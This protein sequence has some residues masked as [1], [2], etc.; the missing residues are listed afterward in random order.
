MT[1]PNILAFETYDQW[2]AEP[3]AQLFSVHQFP[4]NGDLS[5]ITVDTRELI[6]AFAFK[7]HSTLG[8]EIMDAFPNLGLI[9]NYGVGY[10]TIDVD[11]ASKRGIKVT[12]TPDV[13]TDDVA[14][15]GVGM[16]LALN[17]GMV[18]ADAWVRSVNWAA[19]GA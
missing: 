7:G 15:L 13:L 12:N 4:S 9:A 5:A 17:R 3:M 8:P 19:N 10:D 2:D 1:K 18:G 14:D 11:H 6:K 16:V